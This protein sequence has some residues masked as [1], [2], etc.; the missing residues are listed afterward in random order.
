MTKLAKNWTSCLTST[1]FIHKDKQ[2]SFKDLLKQIAYIYTPPLLVTLDWISVDASWWKNRFWWHQ[3]LLKFSSFL[4]SLIWWFTSSTI[5]SNTWR[6]HWKIYK[7]Y[8]TPRG[9]TLAKHPES[10]SVKA[11]LTLKAVLNSF[12]FYK[13]SNFS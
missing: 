6:S 12:S 5:I 9:Y 13:Y 11:D 2:S 7:R 10:Y 4:L 1:P 8:A 3:L